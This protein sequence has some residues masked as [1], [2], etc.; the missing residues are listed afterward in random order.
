VLT[1]EQDAVIYSHIH[2]TPGLLAL[3]AAGNDQA[4]ADALNGPGPVVYRRATKSQLLLWCAVRGVRQKLQVVADTGTNG[5]QSMAQVFLDI[6]R[7]D[8]TSVE[9]S[10]EV[11]AMLD[12]MVTDAVI[13]QA[14]KDDL[15][16]RVAENIST[17][18]WLVGSRA[19]IEDIG[20][21]L[22]VDRPG[23]KIPKVTNGSA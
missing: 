1:P 4:V 23:G 2:A 19:T 9:L 20:R 17:A 3:A 22:Y 6:L 21:I 8:L 13:S 14:D 10:A 15:F 18:E 16:A 7:S 12:R 5:K 11:L